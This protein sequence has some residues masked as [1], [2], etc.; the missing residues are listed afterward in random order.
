MEQVRQSFGDV[1]TAYCLNTSTDSLDSV[2]LTDHQAEVIRTLAPIAEESSAASSDF[3]RP[4][5]LSRVL[6]YDETSQTSYANALRI[7]CGG[8]VA[9]VGSSDDPVEEAILTIGRDVYAVC[10]LPEPKGPFLAMPMMSV[11]VFQHPRA[12][13]VVQYI[14]ADA[15]LSKLFPG[16]HTIGTH[17]V[18]GLNTNS[19]VFWS[20]GSG[21]SFQLSTLVNTL[22]SVGLNRLSA[23]PTVEEYLEKLRQV[24]LT[25]RSLA[26][27]KST[28][29]PSLI[30]L[31]NVELVEGKAIEFTGGQL[32]LPTAGDK[33]ILMNAEN[34]TVVLEVETPLKLVS[35][36]HWEPG[37]TD[38]EDSTVVWERNRPTVE[39]YQQELRRKVDLARLSML[40][41]SCEGTRIAPTEMANATVNPLAAGQAAGM[42]P[43]RHPISAF[44]A[45]VITLNAGL[46]IQKWSAKVASHPASLDMAMRRLLSSVST[47]LDPM[48]GFVDAVICWENMFGTGEGEVSFRVSGAIAKLLEPDDAV[49][50]KRIFDEVKI[51]Y[52]IRSKLVHGSKEPKYQDAVDQRTRS[53]EIA[54]QALQRLYD[55]PEVLNAGD[56]SVRGRILLLGA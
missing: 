41:G 26:N 31:G 29:V 55:R 30:G 19:F 17:N 52:G 3:E 10:L 40:F 27:K 8:A 6:G 9:E 7:H 23:V 39:K 13:D 15:A 14:L 11:P 28:P 44:G 47:R 12:K 33:R 46:E 16:P 36:R 42:S 54:V 35:V 48:D 21:G 34:V 24:V 20:D 43:F 1:F 45:S 49:A 2:E 51:L 53:V 22:L 37:A 18:D 56:S 4:Y 38:D 5:I 25:S 50:R 32:R